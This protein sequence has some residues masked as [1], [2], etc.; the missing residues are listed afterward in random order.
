VL[1]I[2]LVV[3]V[4]LLGI[5]LGYNFRISSL[6]KSLI[7][8]SE[9]NNA[10]TSLKGVIPAGAP[11]KIKEAYA[12]A[13]ENMALFKKVT[14]YCGCQSPSSAGHTSLSDCFVDKI[15]DNGQIV[16]SEHGAN[17]HI[18]VNEATDTKQWFGEGKSYEQIAKSIDAK[19]GSPL[20]G[21]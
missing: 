21:Q 16:Y 11:K 2:G 5:S 12:F 1:T 19:Y 9:G 10:A 7:K 15:K 20:P 3:A 14:C 13:Q 17:C 4:V 8:K 18:C 6:N